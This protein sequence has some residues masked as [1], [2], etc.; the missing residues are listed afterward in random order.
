MGNGEPRV[1]LEERASTAE[2]EPFVVLTATTFRV[3][4]A[5]AAAAPASED[6]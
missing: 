6:G 4:I 1:N 3:A 5:A 2:D